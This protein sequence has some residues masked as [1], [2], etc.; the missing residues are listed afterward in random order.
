V[1]PIS[2]VH[3][4]AESA[5]PS[6]QDDLDVNS[7]PGNIDCLLDT[8]Q[9]TRD[10]EDF[11]RLWIS[12]V[13]YTTAVRDGP[14]Y[15][16]FKWMFV[17]EGAPSIKVYAAYESNGGA[18]YLTDSTTAAAQ[19]SYA[20]SFTS[21]AGA[22]GAI[23]DESHQGNLSNVVPTGN[24]WD[25]VLP[26]S[27]FANVTA[28]Q[29]AAHLLL[30]G[31]TSGKGYLAVVF[32]TKDSGGAF[33]KVNYGPGMWLDLKD[34]RQMYERFTVGDGSNDDSNGEMP[35]GNALL[36][37]YRLPS[38]VTTPFQYTAGTPG[39]SVA[40][41][42]SGNKY[43]MF[44]HGW[45]LAP[46]QRDAFAETMLKRLYWQ[47]YRGKFGAFQ[48]PTTWSTAPWGADSLFLFDPGEYVAYNSAS[49]L[50]QKLKYLR[51]QYGKDNLFLF[52]HSH[53][54]IVS[55]E[56]L[57]LGKLRGDG[58]LVNTYIAS[59]AAVP[60][61][62][63][64]PSQ[65]TPSG[66]FGVGRHLTDSLILY[67]AANLVSGPD[68]PNLYNN[69]Y[70]ANNGNS[71]NST[72][73]FFNVNDYALSYGVWD[74]DQALKPDQTSQISDVHDAPL[75]YAPYGYSGDPN[76]TIVS[77]GF[78]H[79]TSALY[80]SPVA[81]NLIDGTHLND[82]YEIFAFAAEPRCSALGVSNITANVTS[83]FDLQSVWPGDPLTDHNYHTHPWHSAPFRF[84]NITQDGYW[85]ELMKKFG[86]TP[87]HNSS[88]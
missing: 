18:Q 62:T 5:Y 79:D 56:A 63:Y 51:N 3:T 75:F 37:T 32:L 77:N 17:S 40:G 57:R 28:L 68:T 73:N 82:Q 83:S 85:N 53:G 42:T 88:P 47:G 22:S 15:V 69:W 87:N 59:E 23:R 25:F 64:D 31:C 9:G 49:A 12:V 78:H 20:N 66:F 74:T 36:S 67:V 2:P 33:H 44:V 80:A 35:P 26:N 60:V 7:D 30:E 55:S 21:Y 43:I 46:W 50:E 52:S 10:L 34:I 11:A 81:M 84:D 24:D 38:G 41:D 27:V 48:W 14:I 76:G 71:T 61:H 29:P 45:N 58:Q 70:A 65:S 19:L 4:G 13:G 72:I 6:V 86:L 16:G 39:L 1:L 8:I 54:G